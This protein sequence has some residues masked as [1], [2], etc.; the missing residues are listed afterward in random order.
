MPQ[1]ASPETG[2]LTCLRCGRPVGDKPAARRG[3]GSAP[4]SAALGNDLTGQG[5]TALLRP[6]GYDGW[7]TGEQ[8]KHVARLLGAFEDLDDS[9]G[10]GD[11]VSQDT[12]KKR[13][14]FDAAHSSPNGH[15]GGRRS[16]RNVTAG[17]SL[18]AR[19]IGGLAV[20]SL[21]IGLMAST[22]GG[23]LL[24]WAIVMQ[25]GDLWSVGLPIGVGGLMALLVSTVLQLDRLSG[26]H[27]ETAARLEGFD[28][29]L[30]QLRRDAAEATTRGPAAGDSLFSHWSDDT[31]PQRFLEELRSRL[32]LLAKGLGSVENEACSSDSSSS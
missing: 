4:G 12:S 14:R 16:P 2:R 26:D 17:T 8:L 21:M 32:D 11:G 28:A 3:T 13:H 15:H 23:V 31:P 20:V 29:Y 6:S 1:A 5:E 25:R 19:L 22:C 18:G 30:R 10:R 27:R 24:G 7:E 9:L